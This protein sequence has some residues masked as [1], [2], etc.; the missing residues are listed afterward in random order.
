MANLIHFV[1]IL[2]FSSFNQSSDNL[3]NNTFFRLGRLTLT[4]PA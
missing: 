3:F 4:P 2:L 1:E